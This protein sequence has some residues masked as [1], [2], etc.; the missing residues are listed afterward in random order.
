MRVN[1]WRPTGKT[2]A[3][4]Q[5]NSCWTYSACTHR[6]RRPGRGPP[7]WLCGRSRCNSLL[8]RL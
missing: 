1:W 2:A 7:P 3:G 4:C 5:G 6:R 8:S